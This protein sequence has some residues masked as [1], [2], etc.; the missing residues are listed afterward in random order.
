MAPAFCNRYEV[1][2]CGLSDELAELDSSPER[3]LERYDLEINLNRFYS[4][5]IRQLPPDVTST[6]F[7]FCLTDFADYQLSPYKKLDFSIPLSLGAICSYWRE[8]AWS[9]PTLWSSLVVR[10]SSRHDSHVVT[11][12]TQEWLTRSG[13]LPL[14]IHILAK[15]E[16]LH[17]PALADII[18]Q[19]SSRWSHLD[20]YMPDSYSRLFRA[21]AP[22]LKSIRFRCSNDTPGRMFNSPLTCPRLERVDLSLFRLNGAN[23]QWDNLTHLILRYSRGTNIHWDNLTH[24]TLLFSLLRVDANS[25][26][27]DNLT[28]LDLISSMSLN[29]SFLILSR[30]PRLV[31][32]K[33]SRSGREG[34]EGPILVGALTLPSLR[35]LQLITIFAEYIL[36]H[37]IAPH[38]EELSLPIYYKKKYNASMEVITSFLK[39]SALHGS[40]RVLRLDRYPATRIPKK[41]KPYVS[42]LVKKGVTVNVLSESDDMVMEYST[43]AIDCDEKWAIITYQP[44]LNG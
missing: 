40:L 16:Y 34:Y 10:F 6:I 13:Q 11:S 32:C 9:T 3:L 33:I 20:L 15:P 23:I 36:N 12:I 35:F 24:L 8:I 5:I 38:L 4:S 17:V 26:Q 7:E 22:M 2:E 19:Y 30:T 1:E 21:T 28:H 41:R 25:I 37:L 43:L 42:N 44:E 18:N 14:S 31:F 27:L 39:E 29:E